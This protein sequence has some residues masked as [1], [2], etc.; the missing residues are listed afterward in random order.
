MQVVFITISTFSFEKNSFTASEGSRDET[1]ITYFYSNLFSMRLMC[2]AFLLCVIH[3]EASSQEIILTPVRVTDFGALYSTY[4]WSP[5]KQAEL[6]ELLGDSLAKQVIPNSTE[7]VWPAGIFSLSGRMTLR[8]K[9]ADYALYHLTT[10]SDGTAVL[11]VPAKENAH[12]QSDM[13]P[14]LRDIYFMIQYAALTF[15]TDGTV[16]DNAAYD[17]FTT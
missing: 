9:M 11:V 16:I 10:M 3:A 15:G 7:D 4:N 13:R 6:G 12:M 2:V 1:P 5:E 8:P 17:Y 14:E